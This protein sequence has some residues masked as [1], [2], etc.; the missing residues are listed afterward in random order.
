MKKIILIAAS[1]FLSVFA[2]TAQDLGQATEVAKSAN[3]ALMLGD[4]E[5]ALNGF[6]EALEL[7]EAC[8]DEGANLVETCKGVIPRILLSMG[9][10]QVKLKNFDA[11]IAKINE[12][13]EA[14]TNYANDDVLE[15][16]QALLPGVKMNQANDLLTKKDFAGAVKVLN[17]I[18][19]GD[20]ENGNAA[21][22]LGMALAS[23]G[24]VEGAKD[25]YETALANG[26][27]KN[28]AKQLST[29]YLKDAQAFIKAKNFKAAAEAAEKSN[30]YVESA[31]AYKLAAAAATQLKD[32][33]AIVANY[34]KYL[35]LAPNAKDANGVIY[36]LAV[37][38]QQSGNKAKAIELYQK[39]VTDP[40]YGEGAKA[41]IQALNK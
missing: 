1:L 41:Q 40:Q 33:E 14:A 3:D 18:L 36:T 5:S 8:G 22:R 32:N 35:E 15:K 7:A 10:D 12:A 29:L 20:P 30:S 39:I 31:N 34:E 24:D 25:A 37:I 2:A 4:N 11:A 16:A 27:E 6:K 13:I 21:L 28:A 23:T 19:A 26:Q 9:K 17:D 38:Q